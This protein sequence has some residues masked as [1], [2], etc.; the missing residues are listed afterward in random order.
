MSVREDFEKRLHIAY[1]DEVSLSPIKEVSYYA[2]V[3]MI[4]NKDDYISK[5]EKDWAEMRKKYGVQDGVY[6]HFTDIKALLNPQYFSRKSKDRNQNM[7]DIFCDSGKIIADKLHEFYQDILDIIKSNKIKIQVS[8]ERYKKNS[9]FT[10]KIVKYYNNGYWYPLFRDHLDAMAYYFLKLSF[11]EYKAKLEKNSSASLHHHMV[12]LRYDGDFNLSVR[13]DFR[14]AFSHSISNGTRRFTSDAFKD[15]FDEVRFIDKSEIGY[16]V[17]C[18][19][20]CNSRLI[21][22][23]GSEITDFLTVYVARH[24]TQ[25]SITN[26]YIQSG[27]GSDEATK[28]V[29]KSMQIEIDGKEI[30]KPM[31]VLLS[32]LFVS[33]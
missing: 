32:K 11:D 33:P 28:K 23:A 27:I 17:V 1:L 20:E 16:C 29:A 3:S 2:V 5:T 4:V 10:D 19:N 22:H 18:P 13:N 7:E 26:D 14:N 30:I 25:V 15:I 9:F 24:I 6:L 8:Y 12:K 21:N 31:D